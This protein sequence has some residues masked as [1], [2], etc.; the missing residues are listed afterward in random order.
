MTSGAARFAQAAARFPERRVVVLGDVM[1]DRYVEGATDRVSPEAPVPVVRVENE[2]DVMGGAANVAA[3]VRGLGARCDLVGVAGD[4]EAGRALGRALAEVGVGRR[5]VASPGRPTTVKTR[6][7]AQGQ[8]VVRVDR[9]RD[10]D[11]GERVARA[12]VAQ[13]E[14]CLDG[15]GA[16]VL[17]DYDKGAVSA[18][19]ARAALDL[20]AAG[21]VP[22]V[23]DPKRRSFFA[24]AG[25][26]VFKPNRNELEHALGEAARPD[27]PAWM[28]RA[29]KRAGCRH[30][31]LTLGAGGMAL[32]SSGGSLDRV[33]V[34]PRA[35][36]DVS[37]AGDTVSAVVAVA[38]AAGA[39]MGEAARWAAHGAAAGL[40][41]VGA[42]AV[43][44]QSIHGS[45]A[46]GG[47]PD[48]RPHAS[49]A[50]PRR[51]GG[52]QAA[53]RVAIL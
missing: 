12:L 26:T 49:G 29:R 8:Q 6:V 23:V 45:L 32:A 13:L 25:A 31:L 21:G 44:A 11:H 10:D 17:A 36:Y 50:S 48:V 9:E 35:V 16:L 33:R 27:D 51:P 46:A 39:G 4:D 3:N 40:A 20:A 37:G 53:R 2:W 18:H 15:A 41:T 47:E 30:L 34:V 24:Y 42:T 14:G 28:E 7:L 22:V 19:V 52:G 5:F 43:T 1:L 38:L